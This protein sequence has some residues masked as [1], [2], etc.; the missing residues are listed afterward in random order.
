MGLGSDLELS[1][2]QV[3]VLKKRQYKLLGL[4]K[5]FKANKQV[6]G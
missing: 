5:D 6:S 2:L 3:L 4:I 1:S